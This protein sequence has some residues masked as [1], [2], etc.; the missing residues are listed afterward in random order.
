[1]KLKA[2]DQILKD[3]ELGNIDIAFNAV[4]KLQSVIIGNGLDF[5]AYIIKEGKVIQEDKFG[6]DSTFPPS[7]EEYLNNYLKVN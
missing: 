5:A 4:S 1:M 3:I 6:F 2:V 7:A